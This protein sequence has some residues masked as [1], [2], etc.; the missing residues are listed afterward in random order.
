MNDRVDLCQAREVCPTT[1]RRLIADGALMVDVRELR[2][3]ARVA[4]DVPG[5]V[6]MPLSELEER[7]AELPRDRDLVLVC[8]VGERSLK[9]MSFLMS[10]G[11]LRVANMHGGLFEWAGK[12]FP[13]KGARPAFAATVAGC[14]A[15]PA[16]SRSC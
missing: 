9:A 12:G 16:S 7:F 5:V 6:L 10:Q 15:G 14:C 4:F 2:E 13:I 1:T 8:L 3:V 11:Y